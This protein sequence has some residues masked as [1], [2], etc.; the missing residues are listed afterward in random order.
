[1]LQP[2][3]LPVLSVRYTT[4]EDTLN[5]SLQFGINLAFS[6]LLCRPRLDVPVNGFGCTAIYTA[7]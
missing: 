1:M 5:N 6:G 7:Q 2:T 4:S 3:H